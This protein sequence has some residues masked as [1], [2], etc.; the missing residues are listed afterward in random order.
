CTRAAGWSYCCLTGSTNGPAWDATGSTPEMPQLFPTEH[1]GVDVEH[2]LSG[3]CLG[4]EHHT[5]PRF[6]DPLGHGDL[7]SSLDYR[8]QQRLIGSGEFDKI[9]VTGLRHNQ[10]MRV[11]LR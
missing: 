6:R 1:M 3:S 4:V 10:H 2:C 11:R 9:A 5:I 7:S 8:C